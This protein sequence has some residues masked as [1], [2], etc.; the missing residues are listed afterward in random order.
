EIECLPTEI[1]E[2]FT[3]DISGLN[4]GDALHVSDLNIDKKIKVISPAN[5]TI[6]TVVAYV[7]ETAAA[8]AATEGAAA[9][10]A[11]GAAAAT[12]AAGSAPAAKKEEKK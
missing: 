5:M 9:T 2:F 8:S 10:P 7:D 11:A 4:V 6:A 3:A 1:P 12:P